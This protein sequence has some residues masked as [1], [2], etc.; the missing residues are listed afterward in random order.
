MVLFGVFCYTG[1][2][3]TSSPMLIPFIATKLQLQLAKTVSSYALRGFKPAFPEWS[4]ALE[5][6]ISM[7]RYIFSEY[8]Q[9]IVNENAQRMRAP[10]KS[11]GEMILSSSCREHGTVPE[12]LTANNLDHMWLRD[13][14]KKQHHV[15][16]IHFH[17]GG[18]CVSDPLLNIELGNQT[19]IKLK[20]ILKT[21]YGLDVSVD[22]LLARY[23]LAPEYLYP[24]A[25]ND[26]FDVYRYVLEHENIAPGQV[27]FSGD[28][29]GAEM[30]ITNCM[31][32]RKERPELQ[33]ATVLCYSPVV[34]FTNLGADKD[35]PYCLLTDSFLDNCIPTYLRNVT[36]M[37]E[38]RMVSPINHSLRE[39]PP[40]FLQ[41][42][43]LERFYE[44]GLRFKAKSDAEGVTN[45]EFD[46]VPN[47]VHDAVMFPA[48]INPLADKGIW[49]ACAFA[50]KH[51][52]SK[53]RT[54]IVSA[55]PESEP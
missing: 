42:G 50:A 20:H 5:V 44:Q 21:Q 8:S 12:K 31:R 30:S 43:A 7:T 23:R 1:S 48:A 15:V 46:F 27:V 13:P 10:I 52:A 9:T 45:M 2:I 51:L 16:V 28:S 36:D 22:V 53:L 38:R 17:G 4:F 37:D 6:T 32:L 41:W 34:D 54:S 19:H 33:P 39:L 18:Y 11:Y 14:D 29:A 49:N 3:L 47:M 26:C 24:T 25:L 40:I 55:G 35:T